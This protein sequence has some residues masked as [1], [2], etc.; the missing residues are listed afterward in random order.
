MIRI[1]RAAVHKDGWKLRFGQS[2]ADGGLIV[3]IFRRGCV[4]SDVL[5]SGEVAARKQIAIMEKFNRE[6]KLS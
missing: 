5:K 4:L 3:T 6:Q 1:L 2:D